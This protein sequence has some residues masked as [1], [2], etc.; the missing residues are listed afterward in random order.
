MK[1]ILTF[2]VKHI[3]I[4]SNKALETINMNKMVNERVTQLPDDNE[5]K[6]MGIGIWIR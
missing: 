5:M 2:L 4:V 1:Y 6:G 3:R